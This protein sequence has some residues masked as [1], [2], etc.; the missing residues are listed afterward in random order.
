MYDASAKWPL[1]HYLGRIQNTSYM[2]AILVDRYQATGDIWNL[3]QASGLADYILT[4]QGADGGY[5]NG[6]THYT[7]VGYM[8]KQI[9]EVALE[10][11]KLS[12]DPV[13][14]AAYE[15]HYDSVQRAIDDLEARG[16]NVHTEGELTFE[17]GMIS[18]TYS[19]LGM[20]AC[21]QQEIG[22]K[23]KYRDA[24][25]ALT[26]KHRCLSQLL[27][28][29]CRMNGGSLRFWE[30][31]YDIL[32]YGSNMMNSVHGW[33]AWRIYGLWYN[34]LLTGQEKWLRQA[35]NALGSCVQVIDTQSGILRWGFVPDPY[36][37]ANVW[38]EDPC[39]P[40]TGIGVNE[41]IGEQY[42]PMISDWH[43]A[44]PDTFV[45]GYSRSDG[46]SCDNDVHEIFKCLEE[47]ALTS[48]YV[49]ERAD[50][51]IVSWNCSAVKNG[52]TITVTPSEDVVSR[53]HLNLR[54]TYEIDITF[55]G[56]QHISGSYQGMHW[57]GPGGSP[58][59][60]DTSQ[61]CRSTLDADLNNDCQV[62]Y[63]DLFILG[64]SW[65]DNT[66]QTLTDAA[67][68][69]WTLDTDGSDAAGNH[70]GT[71]VGAPVSVAG[72]VDGAFEFA[73]GEYL[74]IDT[75]FDRPDAFTITAW[76]KTTAT[77]HKHIF[78]WSTP[79]FGALFRI[80]NGVLEYGEWDGGTYANITAGSGLNDGQW[81][82]VAVTYDNTA[83]ELYIDGVPANS[84]TV[85]TYFGTIAVTA[86]S[87]GN[88][89]D[90]DPATYS[91][92]GSLDDVRL[93]NT[94]LTAAEIV[95]IYTADEGP[96]CLDFPPGD[97][98]EDCLVN[99]ADF[100]I[101]ALHWLECSVYP[102]CEVSIP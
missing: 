35:Q 89:G 39:N 96:I 9:M 20:F 69:R 22:L 91:I 25:L 49:L 78:G 52:N 90:W 14:R 87:V 24:A 30:A 15:R 65:L 34:Y 98:N 50:D 81:Y 26:D 61:L 16:E 18:C 74:S 51:S 70:D 48:A 32:A 75:A 58:D 102:D 93:Y 42:M 11:Q 3:E 71:F 57:V 72:E 55:G 40:G 94:A 45:S 73:A 63:G 6:G 12:A 13:W 21:L 47:V 99:L 64:Q 36:I 100:A 82:H 4:Q 27:I 76:V 97:Y 86:V 29:D 77:G 60:F 68:A 83:T 95:D 46:G 37:A 1:P 5:Y 92:T 62:D 53:V 28:P 56:G 85:A 41:I 66:A 59:G 101:L 2:A 43:Q 44:P 67:E 33:S 54:N 23:H 8:A 17:D 7:S 38:K 31:Q 80:S 88:L 19:Q 10:E 79:A 84:G